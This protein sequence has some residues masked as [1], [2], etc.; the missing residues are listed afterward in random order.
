MASIRSF[1]ILGL[2]VTVACSSSSATPAA[3]PNATST[4]ITVTTAKGAP[5]A[6]LEVTLST[7][8]L[9][10]QATGVIASDST[11]GGGQVSFTNL[12]SSGQVCV[13][14]ATTVGGELFRANHC[15]A[16]FPAKYTLKFSS[17]MP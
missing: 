10:G 1:A 6:H 12:P 8:L 3:G 13:S 11:N 7:G 16:P 4:I 14:T 9:N 2:L 5:M 15:A 17:K